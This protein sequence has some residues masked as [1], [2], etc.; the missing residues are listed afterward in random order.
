[1]GSLRMCSIGDNVVD[2]YVDQSLWFP[3]GSAAN[4]AVHSRRHGVDAGYIGIFGCDGAGALVQESLIKEQV[5]LSR[6]RYE[7]GPNAYT[8]VFLDHAGNR[9]FGSHS[10]PY[11]TLLLDA[12]DED[13]LRVCDWLHTGHS[14]ASENQLETMAGLAPVVFDFSQST[15]DYARPLLQHI[16]VAGFSRPDLDDSECYDLVEQVCGL[17]P[18]IA[19]VTRGRRPTIAW[20]GSPAKQDV[21]DV[22]VVDTLGAGDA[23]IAAFAYSVFSGAP[24]K[25]GLALASQYAAKTCTQL[26]AFGY[27]QEVRDGTFEALPPHQVNSMKFT[28][29]Q[30]STKPTT[31]E[32]K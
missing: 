22:G 8:D 27:G 21:V 31:R 10:T 5:D 9:Y 26:G 4:V 3:G 14:S 1:M 23:F 29:P 12:E 16:R 11:S 18:T 28:T 25:A 2:R 13:Y 19:V 24:L 17:G 20:D 7:D 30:S 6:V 32:R 15:L